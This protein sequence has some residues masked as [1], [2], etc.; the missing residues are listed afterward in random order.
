MDLGVK[1]T[2]FVLICITL[3]VLL[4]RIK[5][6][7]L[8]EIFFLYRLKIPMATNN[9]CNCTDPTQCWKSCGDLGKNEMDVDIS[10]LELPKE[11]FKIG[12]LPGNPKKNLL[13]LSIN[14]VIYNTGYCR[15]Q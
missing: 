4:L 13:S 8:N 11:G 14:N 15:Q 9:E 3:V 7:V 12:A 2:Y 6:Y 10:N 5:P 1:I